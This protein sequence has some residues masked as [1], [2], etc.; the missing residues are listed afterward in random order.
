MGTAN[1]A[2]AFRRLIDLA[3]DRGGSFYLT[4]HR[5]ATRP[6]LLA[7]YPE[8]P[9]FFETKLE[10]DPSELFQS[11]WYRSLRATLA[12]EE[13]AR[14]ALSPCCAGRR[15]RPRGEHLEPPPGSA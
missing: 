12:L 14:S 6:Q 3:V 10:Q 11:D 2:K 7:A 4:Y 13:A 15:A 1:A 5:W 8:L 9:R